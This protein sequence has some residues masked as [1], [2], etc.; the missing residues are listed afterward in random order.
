M[1]QEILSFSGLL[2]MVPTASQNI[3]SYTEPPNPAHW[4]D[5]SHGLSSGPGPPREDGD[6]DQSEASSEESAVDEKWEGQGAGGGMT[7]ALRRMRT[8]LFFPIYL[9]VTCQ[10]IPGIIEVPYSEER[11][12]SSNKFCHHDTSPA[13]GKR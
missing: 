12:V 5:P 10:G 7:E 6:P 2:L 3:L 8:L 11:E 1:D 13:L 9:L 4:A